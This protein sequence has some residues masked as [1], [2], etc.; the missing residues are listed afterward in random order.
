MARGKGKAAKST[1]GKE[2]KRQRKTESAQ[3][4]PKVQT[5]LDNWRASN[6]LSAQ[7]IERAASEG[8][9]SALA[10]QTNA[11]YH[12][13]SS[14]SSSSSSLF[15][16]KRPQEQAKEVAPSITT[17]SSSSSTMMMDED[18]GVLSRSSSSSS[19][20]SSSSSSNSPDV[21]FACVVSHQQD[22]SFETS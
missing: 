16:K 12:D 20:S 21:S 7:D 22:G 13:V 6:A 10:I 19:T 5:F 11:Q 3:D 9:S 14:L 4:D 2:S 17:T 15:P 1:T 18:D 8:A